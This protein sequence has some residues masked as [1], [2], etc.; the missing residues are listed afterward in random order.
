MAVPLIP[1]T[2]ARVLISLTDFVF[3]HFDDAN[4]SAIRLQ[5][6]CIKDLSATGRIKRS[7]IE[8]DCAGRGGDDAGV[9]FSEVRIGVVEAFG[10]LG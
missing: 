3:R 10:H 9:E 2:T 6:A 8:N 5:A 1:T 4:A 7:S